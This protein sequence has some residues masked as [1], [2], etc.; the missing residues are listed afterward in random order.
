MKAQSETV[1]YFVEIVNVLYGKQIWVQEYDFHDYNNDALCV[2][3][4]YR[5]LYL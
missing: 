3:S 1:F 4:Y 5:I 2:D